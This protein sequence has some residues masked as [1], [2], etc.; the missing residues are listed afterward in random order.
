MPKWALQLE[1]DGTGF[2]GWQR[3]TNGLSVQQIL[4]TAAARLTTIPV[5]SIVAGR[6][7][8]GVHACGQVAHIDLDRDIAPKSLAAALN[9]H[10]RPYPVVVLQAAIVPRDF[11]ARF[12]AI[13]RA[14]RYVI[15]NRPS[16][17]ALDAR[18]VWHLPHKLDAEAMHEAAQHLL[19]RHDFS[20][21]RAAACQAKSPLRTLSGLHVRRHGDRIVIEADARSFLHHQVRNIAG[22]LVQVGSGVWAPAHMAHVLQARDRRLA[23]PTAPPD[24]LTLVGVRYS[25][26]PFGAATE[27]GNDSAPA[28]S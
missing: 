20:S 22:S 3:Q 10:M 13:G 9:Y 26:D 15:L 11:S 28:E 27:S 16:P 19:G 12:S 25:V 14:Y 21:F 18:R 8:S 6:T 4:E 17:P 7:D 1:Y 5:A 2:V 24:G 23:G